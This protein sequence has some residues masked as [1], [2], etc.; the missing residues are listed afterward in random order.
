MRAS[1]EPSV[2]DKLLASAWRWFTTGNV[3]VKVGVVLSLFGVAFL[4]K[5]GIDRRLLVLPI[6]LR[7]IFAALFGTG[8]LVLGWRLRTRMRTYALS[9][10]GGGVGVLYLTIYASFALYDKLPAAVAFGL[11]VAVTVAAVI[12]RPS[13]SARWRTGRG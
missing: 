11:L 2:F 7:L 9:I 6:E 1:F 4:V 5:W 12:P 10:Q 8:L 3:P 13:A